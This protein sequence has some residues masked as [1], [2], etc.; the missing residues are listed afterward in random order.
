[1]S[2]T[3]IEDMNIVREIMDGFLSQEH[4]S[5]GLQQI[6]E[7]GI[8]G[9][10]KWWQVELAIYLDEYPGVEEWDMEHEFEVDRRKYDGDR[11][12]V[13]F[14]F[15]YSGW[16]GSYVFLELKQNNDYKKCI[17]MMFKDAEKYE[18]LKSKSMDGLGKRSVFVVGMFQ[19]KNWDDIQ[20]YF[21]SCMEYYGFEFE[22]DE[23]MLLDSRSHKWGML[24][25]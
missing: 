4:I 7:I 10:E 22:D 21:D 3:F 1:M 12:Y 18:V 24:I 11:L 25:F 14:G 6:N 2:E 16:N 5:K 19:K 15:T 9:W 8:T 17:D 23:F 20:K 13:D